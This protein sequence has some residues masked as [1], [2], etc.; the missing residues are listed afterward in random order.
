MLGIFKT[1]LNALFGRK[2]AFVDFAPE[3]SNLNNHLSDSSIEQ[4]LNTRNKARAERKSSEDAIKNNDHLFIEK[5]NKD[6]CQRILNYWLDAELFDLPECPVDYKKKLISEPADKFEKNWIKEAEEKFKNGK[7]KITEN[8][9]L[10]VM[11]QCHRAGYIAKDDEKHPNYKT[12]RTFLVGQSL[13]P[14]RD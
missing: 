10:M 1:A 7:L 3:R 4:A 13:I 12:P 6:R 5:K 2:K 14:R 9:R 11:F 8:S